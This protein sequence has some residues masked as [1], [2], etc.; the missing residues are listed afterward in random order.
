MTGV[1]TCALPI[2][3]MSSRNVYLLDK[4]RNDA[5]VLHNSLQAGMQKIMQGEKRVHAILSEMSQR[6]NKVGSAQLDYV[7]IVEADTFE[8][9]DE[10]EPGNNYYI[11]IACKIGKTRLIDNELIKV[12]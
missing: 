4:E 2:L 5:L 11:L 6:I 3:A 12:Q 10:L 9:I 7:Q 8:F 1:Q